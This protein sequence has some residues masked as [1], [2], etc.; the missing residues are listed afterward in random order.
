MLAWWKAKDNQKDGLPVLAK[1]A[2]QFVGR[3]ASRRAGVER[4]FSKAG[5]KAGKLHVAK[6]NS[7]KRISSTASMPPPT[8]SRDERA[9]TSGAREAERGISRGDGGLVFGQAPR[10]GYIC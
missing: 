1:M 3:P 4:M 5:M 9:C 6:T 10:A 2:R 7:T 8:P